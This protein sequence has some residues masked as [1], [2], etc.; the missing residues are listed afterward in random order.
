[1]MPHVAAKGGAPEPR[2]DKADSVKIACAT[3]LLD[4]TSTARMAFGS[5]CL[6]MSAIPVGERVT[7]RHEVPDRAAP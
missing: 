7:A 6:Q 2:K 4:D 1:M 5:M 3:S